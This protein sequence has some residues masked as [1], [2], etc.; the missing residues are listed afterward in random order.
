MGEFFAD[1]IH[2]LGQLLNAQGEVLD[3]GPWE[4]NVSQVSGAAAAM[5]RP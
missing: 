4:H 1:E 5:A 3:P 2:G